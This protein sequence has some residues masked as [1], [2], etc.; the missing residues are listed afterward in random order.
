MSTDAEAKKGGRNQRAEVTTQTQRE[1]NNTVQ[2]SYVPGRCKI[3]KARYLHLRRHKDYGPYHQ[4]TRRLAREYI[5][6]CL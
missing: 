5:K 2:R 6:N 1:G 4:A 3:L